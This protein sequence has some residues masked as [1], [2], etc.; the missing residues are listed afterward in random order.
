MQTDNILSGNPIRK[1][2]LSHLA[3]VVDDWAKILDIEGQVDTV[4]LDFEKKL[5]TLLRMNSS[6]ANIQLWD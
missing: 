4:I 6:K 1:L 5:L 3:T 2:S